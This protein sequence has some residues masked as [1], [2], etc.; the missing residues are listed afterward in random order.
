[1]PCRTLS[2]VVSIPCHLNYFSRAGVDARE[3]AFPI[4]AFT[5]S[6]QTFVGPEPLRD[7]I[8]LYTS[9]GFGELAIYRS[10]LMLLRRCPLLAS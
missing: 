1:M 6:Q 9:L 4:G 3:D 7:R 10:C 2:A 8:M 5:I